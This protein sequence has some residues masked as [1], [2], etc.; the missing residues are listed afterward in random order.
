MSFLI[1]SAISGT[2]LDLSAFHTLS[3]SVTVVSVQLSKLLP[4]TVI[5]VYSDNHSSVDSPTL[6]TL[7]QFF[8]RVPAAPSI[9]SLYGS[10]VVL[11]SIPGTS[12]VTAIDSNVT[13]PF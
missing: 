12:Y 3:I 6:L 7:G 10:L 8:T 2:L 11:F 5:G 4:C 9:S 13:D 1:T